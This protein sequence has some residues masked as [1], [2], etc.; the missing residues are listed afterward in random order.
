MKRQTGESSGQCSFDRLRRD[1]RAGGEKGV[2][3]VRSGGCVQ[4]SAQAA[5]PVRIDDYLT[6]DSM[7][8]YLTCDNR[9]RKSHRTMAVANRER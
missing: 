1:N 3:K 4:S 8:D 6:C 5:M 2:N 9:C 7:D